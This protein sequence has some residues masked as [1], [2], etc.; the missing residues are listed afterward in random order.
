MFRLSFSFAA[1]FF[2]VAA[3]AQPAFVPAISPLEVADGDFGNLSPRMLLNVAGEP[4]VFFGSGGAY[5][6][7]SWNAA[8]EAFNAPVTLVESGVFLSDSE[9]PRVASHGDTFL[10]T[11]MISGDWTSGA[12]G[13]V[14]TDAGQTWSPP[15]PLSA[16]TA[17]VDHFMPVPAFNDSGVPFAGIKVGDAPDVFEG[18]LRPEGDIAG[19]WLDPVSSSDAADGDAVCECCPSAPFFAMGRYW[20]VVRNNNSNV[21]DMWLL[22]SEEG[23][24]TSWPIAVDIDPTDWVI[25]GCPATGASVAGPTADGE[26]WAAFMS[27]GGDV[28]QSRVYLARM[29]LQTSPPTALETTLATPTQF[30][31]STQN[32]PSLSTTGDLIALAWEQN[33]AGYDIYLSLSGPDGA[34]L[35]DGAINLTESLGGQHRMPTVLL[36]GEDLHLIWKN[37]MTGGVYYLTGSVSGMTLNPAQTLDLQPSIVSR[38]AGE[39]Q[40]DLTADWINAAY[41]I[42][43]LSGRLLIEGNL[44]SSTLS[45]PN[46]T[47][48]IL[49]L[50]HPNLERV[51]TE[52][53]LP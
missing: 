47:A 37:S 20:N 41:F 52:R 22:G 7:A 49:Q 40:L 46:E 9:G 16:P 28:G 36:S 50:V 39:I 42:H 1:L 21:R 24:P 34:G 3:S 2:L 18:I 27:A 8:A 33:T 13:L 19:P 6:C 43:D 12:R 15:F 29:N 45:I 48:C 26:H 44:T 25:G 10:V 31:N 14:S 35:I 5:H 30:T 17:T 11:Y 38:T 51:W 32:H 53:L 23:D 4:V